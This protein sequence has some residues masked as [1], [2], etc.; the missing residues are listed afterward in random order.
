MEVLEIKRQASAFFS[1]KLAPTE[2]GTQFHFQAG[3]CINVLT[4]A[5]QKVCFSIASE[6]EEKKFI[7]FLL[8]D[9]S[10]GAACK[11][12]RMRVG[13]RLKISH[14]FGA[15]FPIEQFKRNDLLLVGIGSGLAPLRS[16][17]KS[18]LRKNH[19]FQQ[20]AL[21]YGARSQD[22]I[23]FK[24][25]FD[26]WAK[27]IKVQI[28]VS[29]P[30]GTAWNGFKGRVTDLVSKLEINPE[31]TI[32]CICGNPEMESQVRNL[33]ETKGVSKQNILLNY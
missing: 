21:L 22:E 13:D 5:E 27:K 25:E 28:A 8:K 12:S 11:I 4:A 32:C 33:L 31:G 26:L 7:E 23:P 1:A 19:Q 9:Q 30:A 24:D 29:Q 14:P 16:L 6:P 10:S 17:L 15:G 18:L 2:D 20:I 3:Q